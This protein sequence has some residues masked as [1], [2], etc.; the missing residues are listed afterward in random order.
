MKKLLLIFSLVFISIFLVNAQE[1]INYKVLRSYTKEQIKA[2]NPVINAQYDMDIYYLE[3]TTKKIDLKKDTAS[4]IFSVPV[5]KGTKF[6]VLLYEHGTANDR[7]GV[8]SKD[9]N[10]LLSAVIGSYGYICVFPDYIGL[11]ISKGLHPYLHPE[12]EAWA[13]IDMLDAVK[14]LEATDIVNSNNQIFV[15]GYSQG[16]HAAMATS[17]G[18]QDIGTKVTASAPM[19]GPY[20]ISK[21]MKSFTLSDKE[22]YFCGYLGSVVLSAKYVYPDLLD[23]FGIEDIFRPEFAEIVNNFAVEN[24]DLNTMNQR[25]ITLLSKDNGKVIPSRMLKEEVKDKLLTQDTFP[26]N[27]ALKRMDVCDWTPDFP[28]KMLYCTA[29][30]Q[31][32][33]R[34]AVYTDSLMNAQGAEDVSSVDVF[35]AGSHGTCYNFA[36]LNMIKFFGKYQDIKTDGVEKLAVSGIDFYPNPNHGILNYN[37]P[38][39]FTSNVDIRIINLEG[40]VVLNKFIDKNQGS[41]DISQIGK[42]VF[43]IAVNGKK[44]FRSKLVVY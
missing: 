38:E 17:K 31:V 43:L 21:E 23:D 35:S 19:S 26:L 5:K 39:E 12:S 42:G 11:G 8:P 1:V 9:N 28:L 27:L 6:P 13:T 25:M 10:Q 20:S 36:L 29:D 24:I 41:I 37:L 2:I 15:T 32:T 33:Y 14:S 40:R 18:L 3:Y 34:N 44:S 16:G 30:D 4:G 7:N 22:Y